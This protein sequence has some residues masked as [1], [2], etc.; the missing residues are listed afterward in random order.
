MFDQTGARLGPLEESTPMGG[1]RGLG[2]DRLVRDPGFYRDLRQGQVL[3][4]GVVYDLSDDERIPRGEKRHD[5][6]KR[7]T[8]EETEPG[9]RVRQ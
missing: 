7:R 1:R 9:C 5:L 3:C 2:W 4:A 6:F 8:P